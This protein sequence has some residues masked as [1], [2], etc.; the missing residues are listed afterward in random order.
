MLPLIGA[1]EGIGHAAF[2]F[3]D[4]G[5]LALVPDPAYPVYGVGTMFANA[6]SPPA[7][8]ASFSQKFFTI[9]LAQ[10]ESL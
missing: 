10:R 9:I 8:S 4:P 3:L 1:K 7:F 2:C 6:A 5:D